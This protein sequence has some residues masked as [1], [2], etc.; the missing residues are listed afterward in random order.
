[1]TPQDLKEFNKQNGWRGWLGFAIALYT[2]LG[3]A[4]YGFISAVVTIIKG[5][6]Q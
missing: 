2:V 6:T 5:A 3:F 4:V 1:M